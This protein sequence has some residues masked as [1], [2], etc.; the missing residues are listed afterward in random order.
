[1]D[2]NLSRKILETALLCADEPMKIGGL[3]K[4]FTDLDEID[5]DV[6][7]QQLQVLQDEWA[8]KGL[9]LLELASGWR[10]QSRPEMQKYL[11]R[12]N[13][14]KPPKYSRA[15][16]ETL[17]IIAWRQPVTRGDIEDI[18]GVTV[19]SQ[20]IKT[21]EERGWIDVLGHRDA[22][23]RPALLGTTKQFLDDLGLKALDDLPVLESGEAGM[24]DLSGLDMSITASEQPAQEQVESEMI[25]D[26]SAPD[27][28][29]PDAAGSTQVDLASSEAALAD[30]DSE[31]ADDQALSD[32]SADRL[33][34]VEAESPSD[35]AELADARPDEISEV[36]DEIKIGA[37]GL[38]PAAGAQAQN[39]GETQE[40]VAHGDVTEEMAA[41]DETA[42]AAQEMP[43]GFSP[44]S[45]SQ[46]EQ[47]DDHSVDPADE[48]SSDREASDNQNDD[49][50]NKT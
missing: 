3:R 4:L 38:V 6:I 30:S 2:Q 27:E 44:D 11:E 32:E 16:M 26:E 49:L 35:V 34:D 43:A 48:I 20:I 10:F 36:S 50:K 13:P 7:K 31:N 1:M 37:D 40:R 22:P 14:E 5:N 28:S 47:P 39:T 12:L 17:A 25:S 46:N 24:P 9:E 19:S 29:T 41:A 18:R 8:D 42:S 15:V 23:G 33:S 45:T 21:L